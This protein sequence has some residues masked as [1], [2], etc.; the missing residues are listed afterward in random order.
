MSQLISA[1]RSQMDVVIIDT[2]PMMV[3]PDSESIAEVA[4]AV[5]LVVRQDTVPVRIINDTI[6]V[7]NASRA[8]LIGCVLNNYRITEFSEQVGYGYGGRYGYGVK[9]GYGRTGYGSRIGYGS[10]LG[11]GS[12]L[13]YGPRD[14]KEGEA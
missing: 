8:E 5:V 3:S 1:A 2:A 12:R 9:Y 14:G 10:G 6:D 11:Y 4:D 7:L 13:G